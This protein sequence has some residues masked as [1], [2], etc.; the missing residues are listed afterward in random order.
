MQ[1]DSDPGAD[2]KEKS[3]GA[4]QRSPKEKRVESEKTAAQSHGQIILGQDE[5]ENPPFPFQNGAVTS[6]LR[7]GEANTDESE[8]NAGDPFDV[9]GRNFSFEPTSQQ[10]GKGGKESGDDG[11]RDNFPKGNPLS[12]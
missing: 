8:Q 9:F 12:F 5:D 11:K 4:T 1:T 7:H 2:P 10:D 3:A 6:A